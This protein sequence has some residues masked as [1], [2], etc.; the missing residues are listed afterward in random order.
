MV[1]GLVVV[2][3]V[4]II[5]AV[6][7]VVLALVGD[8]IVE[9]EAVVRDN[10]VDGFCGGGGVRKNI[11]RARKPRRDFPAEP[12]VASPKATRVVAKAIVP[13]APTLGK[14][15]ELIAAR[16][17]VPRFGDQLRSRYDG[18]VFDRLKQRRMRI[19]AP[20]APPNRRGEI[21]AKTVDPAERHPAPQSRKRHVRYGGPIEREAIAASHVVDISGAVVGKQTK[22]I[23]V[24]E[25]AERKRRAEFVALS[26]VVE[27][28][29]EDRLHARG[30]Q[31]IGRSS[32]LRPAIGRKARVGRAEE[33]GVVPPGIVEPERG[34]MSLV[35]IGVGR[36][37][38][39]AGDAKS[40]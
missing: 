26:V 30:V 25:A 14:P 20:L 8:E 15:A 23:C 12:A 2:R 5:L 16:T 31:R 38:L 29:V 3:S 32:H 33:H 13:F 4:A 22:V 27:D 1:P 9:R 19:E 28:D 18:I 35:Y 37:D 17:D 36:H 21:E 40:L 11:S 6:R 39:D 24:V 34:Q 10:E 7:L